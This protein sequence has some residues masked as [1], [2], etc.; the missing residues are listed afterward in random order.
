M[1]L[2]KR[3]ETVR[4]SHV[5][6]TFEEQTISKHERRQFFSKK[7]NSVRRNEKINE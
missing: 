5:G 7:K 6:T 4:C 3:L 2:K 1:N